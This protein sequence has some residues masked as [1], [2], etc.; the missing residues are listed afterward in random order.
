MRFEKGRSGNPKGRPQGSLSRR[1]HLVKLLEPNAEKLIAKTIELALS[2]DVNALR[3][4]VERLIPRIK[5]EPLDIELPDNLDKE[6]TSKIKHELIRA[7]LDGQI[8]L[9]EAEGLAKLIAAQCEKGTSLS[10][11]TS[12][13]RD[14]IEASK[15][16]Q[17]IMLET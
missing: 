17:R 2:G 9:D 10:M 15:I 16:Y 8:N 11:P 1:V 12:L 4:C 7:A 3:L 6:N 14:P 5:R 13:G